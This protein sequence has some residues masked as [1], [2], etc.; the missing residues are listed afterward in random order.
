MYGKEWNDMELEGGRKKIGQRS[1]GLTKEAHAYSLAQRVKHD[2][3]A[4][5]HVT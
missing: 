4:W 2:K 1:V 5:N 3:E